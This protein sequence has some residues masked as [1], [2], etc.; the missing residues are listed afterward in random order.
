MR[1][2]RPRRMDSSAASLRWY[3]PLQPHRLIRGVGRVLA[4]DRRGSRSGPACQPAIPSPALGRAPLHQPHP[5][6]MP[7]VARYPDET[8]AVILYGMHLTLLGLTQC[9]NWAYLRE[10]AIARVTGGAPRGRHDDPGGSCLDRS[11]LWSRRSW[12]VSVR[13]R[14]TRSSTS[15][16]HVHLQRG[17]RSLDHRS[18]TR[19]SLVRCAISPGKRLPARQ[20]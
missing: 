14:P 11:S 7:V 9:A 19:A 5:F 16:D 15:C 13:A 2:T 4:R 1:R 6:T 3:E 17:P 8:G 18:L 20:K 10:L 12:R